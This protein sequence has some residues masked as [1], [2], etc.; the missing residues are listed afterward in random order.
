MKVM[1]VCTGNTCRSAMAEYIFRKILEEK[2]IKNVEIYSCGIFAESGDGATFNAIETL[3]QY[4][5]DISKH[6]ATNISESNIKD[7]DL[8]LCATVSHKQLVLNMY[9][10]LLGKVYTIKE[11]AYNENN[12]DIDIKDPWGNNNE[13]YLLCAKEIEKALK[14]IVEKI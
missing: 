13:T 6:R 4:G 11:Y 2:C 1:F 12:Q 10:N 8:I 7:M 14:K 5:I 3:K 9:P